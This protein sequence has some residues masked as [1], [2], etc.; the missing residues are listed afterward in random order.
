MSGKEDKKKE[1]KTTSQKAIIKK[2]QS[3]GISSY[4]IEEILKDKII[5]IK[6]LNHCI[7]KI[8]T[9]EVSYTQD[10]YNSEVKILKPRRYKN[11]LLKSRFIYE[12]LIY[13]FK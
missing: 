3:E 4:K 7:E 8:Y 10:D 1:M 13:N 2:A 11:L 12:T 5:E 9:K 6:E